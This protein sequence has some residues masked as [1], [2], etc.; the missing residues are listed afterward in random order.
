MT[1]WV[2]EFRVNLPDQGARWREGNAQPERRED[3]SILWHGFI[4]D[5]TDRKIIDEQI[6][7]MAQHDPLTNLPNRV[8][9][10]DRLEHALE[11]AK[12]Q[13]TQLALM[14]VDLDNFKDINDHYGHHIGD[15]LLQKIA[16]HLASSLRASDTA[17]RIGG[18]EFVILL[19][20]VNGH[21][22]AEVV[23]EKI[24]DALKAPHHILNLE[25]H[26]S[27]S[28]GVALYP[29]HG[30]TPTALLRA[31]DSAMYQTKQNGRDN[32]NVYETQNP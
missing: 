22:D 3:G 4:A 30:S 24:Q 13:G 5:I 18:D 16:Q 17:A 26:A 8:L 2:H 31:A 14:F 19:Q 10:M 20:P 21:Y 11:L 28:I 23:A 27:A 12:R 25:L 7:H 15:A 1:P 32:V 29:D 9:F 6:R